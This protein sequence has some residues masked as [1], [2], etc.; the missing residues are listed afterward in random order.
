MARRF[1]PAES[2]GSAATAVAITTTLAGW[3][4]SGLRVLNLAA[5]TN[6]ELATGTPRWRSSRSPAV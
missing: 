4:Y 6:H 2:S 5:D 1:Y 3:R